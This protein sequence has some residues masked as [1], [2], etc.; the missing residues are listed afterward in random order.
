MTNI[1]KK[2]QEQE[3]IQRSETERNAEIWPN[4]LELYTPKHT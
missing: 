2:Q 3:W 1:K 4:S